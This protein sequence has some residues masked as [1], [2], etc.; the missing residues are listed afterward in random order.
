MRYLETLNKDKLNKKI[1]NDDSDNDLQRGGF[2][3][4]H[5]AYIL[6]C[7]E[8]EKMARIIANSLFNKKPICPDD[9]NCLANDPYNIISQQYQ[10]IEDE[11][12]LEE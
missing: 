9:L 11:E 7:E 3:E 4:L 2:K 10:I 12:S 5:D 6:K 1:K 8:I